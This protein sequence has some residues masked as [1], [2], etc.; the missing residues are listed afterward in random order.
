LIQRPLKSPPAN[1]QPDK[2]TAETKPGRKRNKPEADESY[3]FDFFCALG[4][5]GLQAERS[6]PGLACVKSDGSRGKSKFPAQ[7]KMTF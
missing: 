4:V 7:P 6:I 5:C 3:G 2:W 1:T